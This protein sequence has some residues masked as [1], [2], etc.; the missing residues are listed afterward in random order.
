MVKIC[1]T[2]WPKCVPCELFHFIRPDKSC[3]LYST[4]KQATEL[5]KI[6]VRQLTGTLTARK[7]TGRKRSLPIGT[8]FSNLTFS[9]HYKRI[10]PCK[11]VCFVYRKKKKAP[12]GRGKQTTYKF[13]QCNIPMCRVEC[14]GITTS[15]EMWR[16]KIR[17]V[18]Y[19]MHKFI[20]NKIKKNFFLSF[21]D[22]LLRF[23]LPVGQTCLWCSANI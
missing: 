7:R 15:S 6:L 22:W 13:K 21:L 4:R 9:L 1:I 11:R 18:G 8:A 2:F 17:R 5:Q 23:F 20:T 3:P 16:F 14:V 10:R 12:S 19:Y